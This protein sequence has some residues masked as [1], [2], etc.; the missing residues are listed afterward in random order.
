LSGA[1][2]GVGKFSEVWWGGSGAAAGYISF[3]PELFDI[4]I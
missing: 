4:S 1:A 2:D 3:T